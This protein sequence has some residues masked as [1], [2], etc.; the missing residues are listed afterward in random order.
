[1]TMS[2]AKLV[3]S[4]L[5]KLLFITPLIV[6]LKETPTISSTVLLPNTVLLMLS[7]FWETKASGVEILTDRLNTSDNAV[8]AAPII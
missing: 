2:F 1:M 4:I 5:I 3:G 6:R 7:P 8:A